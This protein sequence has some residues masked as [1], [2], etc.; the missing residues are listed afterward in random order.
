MFFRNFPYFLLFMPSPS[1]LVISV[2]GLPTL[3]VGHCP[4]F[5][6]LQDIRL[7]TRAGLTPSAHPGF[8]TVIVLSRAVLR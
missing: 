4:H 6:I 3:P 5:N 2:L 1:Y 7:D 8:K